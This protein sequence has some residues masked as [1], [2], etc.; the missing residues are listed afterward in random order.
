M[1]HIR[2]M[3][4]LNS[5]RSQRGGNGNFQAPGTQSGWQRTGWSKVSYPRGAETRSQAWAQV[6]S[7][8]TFHS[9]TYPRGYPTSGRP[10]VD[11][12]HTQN[13]AGPQRDSTSDRPRGGYRH[14]QARRNQRVNTANEQFGLMVSL[15]FE[16]CQLRHHADNWIELPRSINRDVDT[17]FDCINLPRPNDALASQ[18]TVIKNI[19]KHDLQVAAQSHIQSQID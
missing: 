16:I 12:R 1:E 14:A 8:R 15:V 6:P 2:R 7:A 11:P 10:P 5:N 3:M 18:K 13:W 9:R 17:L 4:F 19:L